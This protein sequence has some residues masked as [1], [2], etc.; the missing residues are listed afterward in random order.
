MTSKR[1]GRPA[2]R[3]TSFLCA[4]Y[5]VVPLVVADHPAG[6]HRKFS[7]MLTWPKLWQRPGYSKSS[8]A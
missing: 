4:A 5:L 3:L 8:S 6:E 2:M 1:K 7:V